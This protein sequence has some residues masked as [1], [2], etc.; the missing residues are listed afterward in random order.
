MFVKSPFLE[1][2]QYSQATVPF[3][4]DKLYL[5]LTQN[6]DY[7]II[8]FYMNNKKFNKGKLQWPHQQGHKNL[9]PKIT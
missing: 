7:R 4:L 6:V 3:F 9:N 1:I 2:P 5:S 8:E